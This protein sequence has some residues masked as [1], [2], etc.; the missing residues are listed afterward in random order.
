MRAP[1]PWS[2]VAL[3]GIL[4]A[5]LVAS[6]L[7]ERRHPDTMAYPLESIPRA[8]AGWQYQQDS[9]LPP[10]TFRRLVPSDYISRVYAKGPAHLGLLVAYYAEQRTGESMHSPKHCLPGSGWEIWRY[11][12]ARVPVNGRYVV[13][14][15][16]FVQ[17][18]GVRA[19]VLYWYQSH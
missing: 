18:E 5:T 9:L 11:G 15:N 1:S 12:S 6:V 16:Y 19:I 4:S 13:V 2:V 14:N 3:T 7:S 17:K 8:L 10:R